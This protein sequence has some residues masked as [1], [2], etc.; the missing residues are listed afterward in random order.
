[1]HVVNFFMKCRNVQFRSMNEEN[2]HAGGK[3][4]KDAV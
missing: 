4:V 1:M 2:A 3:T